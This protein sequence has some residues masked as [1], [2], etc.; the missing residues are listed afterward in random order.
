M[1]DHDV[2]RG[3]RTT[4]ADL[5]PAEQAL[6]E[7]PEEQLRTLAGGTDKTAGTGFQDEPRAAVAGTTLS[8]SGGRD[9]RLAVTPSAYCRLVFAPRETLATAVVARQS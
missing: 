3:P 7:L 1:S 5:T 2:I 6:L 9:L 8:R 4:I